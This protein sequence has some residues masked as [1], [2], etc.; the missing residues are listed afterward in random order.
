MYF[1]SCIM[2][3]VKIRWKKMAEECHVSCDEWR[4]RWQLL[5]DLFAVWHFLPQKEPKNTLLWPF[6]VNFS[7]IWMFIWTLLAVHEGQICPSLSISEPNLTYDRP[8][9][10]SIWPR[11]LEESTLSWLRPFNASKVF[12]QIWPPTTVK[13]LFV[14]Q[15]W[16]CLGQFW[17]KPNNPNFVYHH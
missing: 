7:G 10:M 17:A 6:Q 9:C 5:F 8:N 4:S 2:K 12:L 14:G 16:P 3:V 11:H 1:L 15:I 13:W